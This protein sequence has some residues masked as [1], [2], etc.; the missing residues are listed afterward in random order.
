M[1]V[2]RWKDCADTI[3]GYILTRK[4]LGDSAR[5]SREKAK[6]KFDELL[7]GARLARPKRN[8][9]LTST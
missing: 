1:W 5:V 9:S 2:A 6:S 3:P 7:A 4:Y 8:A